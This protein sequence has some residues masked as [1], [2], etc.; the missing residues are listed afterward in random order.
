MR[1]TNRLTKVAAM[2]AAL[3][4]VS[5][6]AL[7][8]SAASAL[9]AGTAATTGQNLA[10]ASGTGTSSF[11]LTLSSN[12]STLAAGTNT[13]PGDGIAGYKWTSY[14]VPASVDVATLT[15]NSGGPIAPSGVAFAQPLFSSSGSPQVSK[16]PGLGDGLITPIPANLSFGAIAN[17]VTNGEYKIGYACTKDGVT[18][19]YWQT[20]IV[21][22]DSDGTTFN[23]VKGTLP[24][25]PVLT[26]G[27]V[28]NAKI[29]GISF[30]AATG[31][32]AVS[33]YTV[34]AVPQGGGS[35]VGPKAA[36]AGAA[37]ELTSADGV[38][39]GKVY[40]VTVTATNANGSKVSN[41]VTTSVVAPPPATAP[42]VSTT[43]AA[44]KVTVNW[45]NSVP[46]GA[47]LN[48]FTVSCNTAANFTGTTPAACASPNGDVSSTTLTKEFTLPVGTYY[49]RV[50]A[51]YAAP[52]VDVTSAS[53]AGSSQS[54]Q[55]LIQNITVVRPAGA[56]VLTQKCGVMGSA[57]AYNDP[58]MG[59]L[60]AIPATT[61]ADPSGTPAVYAWD[62]NGVTTLPSSGAP[63]TDP[64][65]NDGKSADV[66]GPAYDGYPYPVVDITGLG[67]VA[68]PAQGT[69]NAVYTSNTNCDINLGIGK[70]I[71]NGANAGQYFA[72]TGRI[73]QLSVVNTQDID[74][75]WTLNGKMSNFTSTSDANDTFSGNLLGWNPEVTW[76]S[77]ANLDGYN[78]EVLAGDVRQP[79]A[80]SST[81]GLG[82]NGATND[83][84]QADGI[85]AS[86]GEAAAPNTLGTRANSLAKST[87]GKSLGMAVLDARLRLLIPVTADAGTYTGTLTF[88]TI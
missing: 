71:T 78:M 7:V 79:V 23:W 5:T 43:G 41:T 15:Y 47:T 86:G 46:A 74:G 33:G 30:T 70:L 55:L 39:N 37:F 88:T 14:M 12:G 49:F 57:A 52:F 36:T 1:T 25:A 6:V 10:Q 2:A 82:P 76:D 28:D 34:T 83:A 44:G 65:R 11:Q 9:P 26:V 75:G 42:A 38:V 45:T 85:A 18:E 53:V 8:S 87:I 68:T 63:Q 27:G 56:L 77:L 60:P 59:N 51:D 54:A 50:L 64:N 73:N 3:A 32:P 17:L 21:A 4:A 31:D 61:G 24:S 22:K 40:D 29:T 13:C 67:A 80:S 58:Q 20:S 84:A 66:Y 72:T 69:P 62:A 81:A 16:S 19:K 48:G 35:T